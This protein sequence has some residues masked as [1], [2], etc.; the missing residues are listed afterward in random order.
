MMSD[1][2]EHIRRLDERLTEAGLPPPPEV[3]EH[4]VKVQADLTERYGHLDPEARFRLA[5]HL[6]RIAA[7][8]A[9]QT[10]EEG[11]AE[12]AWAWAVAAAKLAG[13]LR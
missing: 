6:A 3:L 4:A 9:S 10:G 8:V 1:T 7:E 13:P 5:D 2:V 12:A 11:H